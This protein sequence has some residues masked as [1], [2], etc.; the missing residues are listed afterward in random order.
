[1]DVRLENIPKKCLLII[2]RTFYS[3]VDHFQKEFS[4]LGYDVKVCNHE[5]PD[6]LIGKLMGKL[7]IPL[8]LLITKKVITKRYLKDEKY[9]FILII[10]GRGMSVSLVQLLRQNSSK[11]IGYNFDSFKYHGAPLK[12]FK[13]VNKYYTFD[14]QNS[15]TYKLDIVELFSNLPENHE[16]KSF[17]YDISAIMRNHSE[18]LQYLDK[19]FSYIPVQNRFIFIYEMN[20]FTF[21]QNFIKNPILYIKYRRNI[22]FKPLDYK[23]YTEVIQNSNFT[24][25]YVYPSQSGISIRCFEALSAQ[26]KI[27]TNNPFVFRFEYF[28]LNNTIIYNTSSNPEIIRNQYE[29]IKNNL[30]KRYNRTISDFINDLIF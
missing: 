18:R 21:I 15:E 3:Y 22:S 20:I 1:M 13:H 17:K 5:Y 7:Q 8:L 2:P 19:I 14:Y 24:L 9:E 11:V 6:S 26:T 10:K 12:W 30:P 29:K 16:P 25:D 27:I 23:N 28:D 4:F